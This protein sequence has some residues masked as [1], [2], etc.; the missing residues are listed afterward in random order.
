MP[1][2]KRREVPRDANR[3]HPGSATAMWNS[4]RL[5]QVQVA[6]I[7]SD[8]GGAG[9]P[10]LRVHVRTVHVHLSAMFVDDVADLA[11]VVLEHAVRR[12]IGDHQ[13]GQSIAM[14]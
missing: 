5:V 14:L 6:D 10:D 1:W 3:S 7:R 11:D 2:K 12:R 8:R 4:K 13:A 9:Q